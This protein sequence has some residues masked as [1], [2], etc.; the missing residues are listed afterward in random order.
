MPCMVVKLF[1]VFFMFLFLT[2]RRRNFYFLFWKCFF[3]F[4]A[5]DIY[6]EQKLHNLTLVTLK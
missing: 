4:M 6:V 2:K 1:I 3:C 5:I